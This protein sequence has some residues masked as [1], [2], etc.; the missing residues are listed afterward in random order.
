MKAP[1]PLAAASVRFRTRLVDALEANGQ[2]VGYVAA[3]KI[4]ARCPIC[5]GSLLVS[6]TGHA[7]RAELDCLGGCGEAEVAAT[8]ARR[9][10]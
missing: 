1:Q 4:D 3:D 8:L 5:G 9:S 2:R 10:A 6:F 7:P